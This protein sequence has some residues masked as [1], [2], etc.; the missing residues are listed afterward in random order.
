M[1]RN[2]EERVRGGKRNGRTVARKL[3]SVKEKK[4][5]RRR[6]RIG[7]I[8][9]TASFTTGSAIRFLLIALKYLQSFFKILLGRGHAKESGNCNATVISENHRRFQAG[10]CFPD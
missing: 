7:W 3:I 9:G 10:N 4:E 1:E 6:I 2:T 8:N 5:E